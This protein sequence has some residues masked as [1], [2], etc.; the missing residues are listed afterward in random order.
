MTTSCIAIFSRGGIV[1][2]SDSDF[3]IRPLSKTSPV[4]MAV[5]TH[6]SIPWKSIIDDYLLQVTFRHFATV[7]DAYESFADYFRERKIPAACIEK[8]CKENIL[9]M[10]YNENYL[11][12][13][14]ALADITRDDKIDLDIS[15]PFVLDVSQIDSGFYYVIGNLDFVSPLLSGAS[16]SIIE[17]VKINE[18]KLLSNYRTALIEKIEGM[19]ADKKWINNVRNFDI[20]NAVD[21]KLSYS[22]DSVMDEVMVEFD[23]LSIGEIA[24]YAESLINTECQ[25]RILRNKGN[26]NCFGTREI[27]V[28]T[29]TEG[30]TWIK[31]SL[32]A[33]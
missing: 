3:S 7:E 33:I 10:G 20:E 23:S 1:A 2:A 19:N 5:N 32:F 12:P 29:S 27:A 21:D 8:D 16:D 17:A 14:M 31:H 13:S 26:G 24:V 28:L 15:D 25:L 18:I 4:A 9:F 6:S 11:Y 30:L 22:I